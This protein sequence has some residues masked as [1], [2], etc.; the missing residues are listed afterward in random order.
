VS[1]PTWRLTRLVF[2]RALAFVYLVAFLIAWNQFVP[3][4]GAHGL[5]P[6]RLFMKDAGFWNGPSLFYWIGNSDAAFRA[7]ALAGLALS[8]AALAGAT[9]RFGMAVSVAAWALL[10][11]LY[12]S[13]VNVGQTFYGFGW[14][15][16][17]LE[18]GFL[19]IFLGHAKSEAPAAVMWLARWTLFR[20]MLGAG[21]IKL[22]GDE[23]WRDLT[24]M[25]YHYETQPLPNPLSWYFH[26]LPPWAHKTEV[27][28]T[29]FVELVAP[30][31]LFF[32]GPVGWAAGA[33]ATA[34]QTL[35]IFSGNLSW[36][37]YITLVLCVACFDDRFLSKFMKAPER[38]FEPFSKAR[39]AAL[40]ALCGLI[41]LLSVAPAMNLLS[42]DQRM[43]ASFE[44]FQLVNTYG[45][46]GSVTRER[47]EIVIEGTD[48][49]QPSGETA[50]KE[51]EFKGKPGDPSRAPCVVSPYHWKL[52]W[53]MWFA[54]MDDYRH[55]PWIL[56]LAAKLLRNDPGTLS[57]VRRNPFPGAP[58]KYVRAVLYLYRFTTAAERKATGNW[59][60][61]T[62]VR[63]YLPPLSLDT[64]ALREIL[65]LA[66]WDA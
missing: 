40:F 23:C 45:A 13:F 44:P 18:T 30:W 32:T 55:H 46:F 35:L 8:A 62:P 66:G 27:L 20:V 49:A 31:G 41:G 28:F 56:N 48:D 58:P 4:V 25:F 29:H 53:Q 7:A 15:T 10:W 54:A 24:A 36:L 26:H 37:N 65:E 19:A 51:Y 38:S 2:Q 59:W 61:R 9:E 21:L 16:L 43:N 63:G 34:F 22:R 42:P 47:F 17:L 5:L 57:L 60:S 14:E 6:A 3:L 12:Q 1:A 64:P 11:A 33:L 39:R 52:D 50:W